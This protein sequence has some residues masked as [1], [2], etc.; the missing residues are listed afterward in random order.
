MTRTPRRS[1]AAPRHGTRAARRPVAAL[2]LATTLLAAHL[3]LTL[4]TPAAAT[5]PVPAAA[6]GGACE[7]GVVSHITSPPPAHDMLQADLAWTLTRGEGVLVAV[8]DS[9]V[10]AAQEHLADALTGGVD[11]VGD[12]LG[13]NGYADTMGH[14]TAVAGIVAAREVEGSGVVGLAPASRLY[15]VRVLAGDDEDAHE[16]GTTATPARIAAGIVAGVDAG[17]QVVAVA[18]S[19]ATD[20]PELREAVAYARD[21]GSLVV[22]SAGNAADDTGP[23]YPAA[24]PGALAVTAVDAAGRPSADAMHGAHVQVAAPGGPALTVAAGSGDCVY[25]TEQA[26]SSFAT[27]YAAAA[28]ALVASAHPDEGPDRWA[29]RLEATAVRPDPDRREDTIGWGLVQPYEAIVLVP[30]PGVRGPVDPVTDAAPEPLRPAVAEVRPGPAPDPWASA[31]G[32]GAV[33]AVLALT[34]AGVLGPL[35]VL[36]A[37]RRTGADGARSTG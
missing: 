10:D 20:A 14:G 12:G 27:G 18:L 34:A 35:V 17:A 4:A 33:A 32:L 19:T 1:T 26:Q 3:G 15:S 24:A 22:A 13:A 8:V 21:R 29:Y 5:G 7:A 28:A 23:R 36:R 25:G 2:S 31:R 37:R 6:A 9:G 30:G 11:L 16:A